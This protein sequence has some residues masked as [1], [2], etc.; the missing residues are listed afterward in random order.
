MRLPSCHEIVMLWYR[1]RAH[2]R[3]STRRSAARS[4]MHVVTLVVTL[5]AATIA[6]TAAPATA[7]VHPTTP[8]TPRALA[9]VL[10]G[11]GLTAPDARP[12]GGATSVR[13]QHAI[14]STR[15]PFRVT[16]AGRYGESSAYA[17]G[18]VD[19]LVAR[20]MDV[21]VL[22]TGSEDA[23]R[24]IG[25]DSTRTNIRLILHRVRAAHPESWI[26]LVRESP[27]AALVSADTAAFRA[28]YGALARSERAIVLPAPA[29]SLW[30]SLEPILRKVATLR[31]GN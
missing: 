5:V 14:D 18:R 17:A 4:A 12:P 16:S 29:D 25:A 1:S 7:Q 9:V 2:T 8:G 26:C 10:L 19:S 13:L 11:T 28:L 30:P 6:A 15:L 24:G 20:S 27:P 23:V 21:F 3:I 31:L 22:E